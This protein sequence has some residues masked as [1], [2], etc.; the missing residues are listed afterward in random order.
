[1]ALPRN[2]PQQFNIFSKC[3]QQINGCEIAQ[4]HCLPTSFTFLSY[5]RQECLICIITYTLEIIGSELFS[6]SSMHKLV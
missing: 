4:A 2:R 3:Y 1:M 6:A 5:N